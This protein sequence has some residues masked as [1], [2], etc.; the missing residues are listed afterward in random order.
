MRIRD[1]VAVFVLSGVPFVGAG[2]ARACETPDTV[3]AL[4]FDVLEDAMETFSGLDDKQCAGVLKV[5]FSTCH[6]LVA[7]AAKTCSSEAGSFFKAQK[8]GC[9]SNPSCV[10]TFES[11]L[12]VLLLT[13]ETQ[14]TSGHRTCDMALISCGS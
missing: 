10:A 1:V 12:D 5:A 8:F 13:I 4:F 9:G 2:A 7:A 14:E 3:P 11:Q 6:K